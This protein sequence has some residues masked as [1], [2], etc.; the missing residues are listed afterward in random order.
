AA[1]PRTI[2]VTSEEIREALS[3]PVT[4]IVERCKS[5]LEQTPPELSADIIERGIWLTGGGALLR[6][7][8]KLMNAATD[9][10]VHV[11]E[12]PLS[13][14]AIG[15]GRALEELRA[16]SQS[17]TGAIVSGVGMTEPCRVG[18]AGCDGQC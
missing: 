14:V 5:V 6:G 16:I 17:E 8:D 1:L 15:T 18:R 3:E 13:C 9:I 2:Q 7:L 11:A 12:D 10:P 4:H